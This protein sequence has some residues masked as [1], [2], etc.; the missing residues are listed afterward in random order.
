MGNYDRAAATLDA[1]GQATFPPIPDVV[2]TPRSGIALT[3]RVGLHFETNAVPA[4]GDGPRVQAEPAMNRWIGGVLPPLGRIGCT[5]SYRDAATLS[6]QST[7]VTA[8][9]LGLQPLD[10]LYVM[11]PDN[12]DARSELADRIAAVVLNDAALA[13]RPDLLGAI[14]YEK[15]AAG[16]YSFFEVAPFLRSLQALLLRSRPL[17]ATDVALPTEAKQDSTT[18]VLDRT[19]VDFLPVMLASEKTTTLVPLQTQLAAVFPSGGPTDTA[20]ILATIDDYITA[21]ATASD[22]LSHYGL[23]QTGFGVFYERKAAFFTKVLRMA[24]AIATRFADRLTQYAALLTTLPGLPTDA[25]KISALLEAERL[26]SVA[27]TDPTGKTVAQVQLLVDT[28]KTAYAA[29]QTAFVNLQKTPVT[30]MT[31]LLTAFEAL[32]PLTQFET[33]ET[34]VADLEND[35]VVLAQDIAGRT[36]QLIA[37]VD[38]RIAGVQGKLVDHDASS[39]PAA[40]LRLLVEAGRLVFGEEF[41]FIPTFALPQAQADEWANA[42]DNREPLLRHHKTTLGNDFPVDDW[43][44]GVARVRDKMHHVENLTFLTEAFQ[45]KSPELRAIQ[46]PYAVDAYWMALEYPAAEKSRLE[47]EL[48]LYTAHYPIDFDPARRQ[49]G[50]LLDE[51]TE[52]VPADTETTGLTFHFDKPN[53]EPPQGWLLALP[54]HAAGEWSWDDLVATLH[55]TLDMARLRAVGPRELDET[56][57]SVF[58]PATI[59]ATTWQ[60]ITIA[61]DLSI[62]NNYVSKMS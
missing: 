4:V 53:A 37:A 14:A 9:D 28:K 35:V 26:V 44:Y 38:A 19:R 17:Q 18:N 42:Y 3:H 7:L 10:L 6:P 60:P 22:D 2:Q 21:I 61:A 31:A 48:L 33:Q 54:S 43:M 58:L 24:A 55:E 40:R 41:V 8:A 23:P 29:R 36:T 32:L 47:R 1:Y 45:T 56:A 16:D 39:V 59:L 46:F 20:T 57:L 49:G 15:G 12:L 51:W 5:V 13:V 52:V 50:L 34:D 62:V 25:D 11:K 30:T 27:P